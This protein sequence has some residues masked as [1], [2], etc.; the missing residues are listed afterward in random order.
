LFGLALYGAVRLIRS[1]PEIAAWFL[2]APLVYT[3]FFLF[4][5]VLFVRNFLILFPFLAVLAARGISELGE[6]LPT[7]N[8]KRIWLAVF[9]CV[10]AINLG[11]LYISANSVFE[12]DSIDRQAD[13]IGYL[14]LHPESDFYLT[15]AAQD[16][17]SR[18]QVPP[19]FTLS[20]AQADAVIFIKSDEITP[21][22]LLANHRG[23][24]QLVSGHYAV[25]IDYYPSWKDW[26]FIL[27]AD[28]ARL[29]ELGGLD[30]IRLR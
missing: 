18:A 21:N 12:R 19:N 5:K 16:L 22:C 28:P 6:R 23:L 1:E 20:L 27:A 8:L 17:L 13:L 4:Q 7:Q 29:D 15:P 9:L 11:W 10:V 26:S 30:C 24:Y 3:A 2:A 14:E 25:N